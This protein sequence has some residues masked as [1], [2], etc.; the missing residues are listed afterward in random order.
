MFM[1]AFTWLMLIVSTSGV[2][3][4]AAVPWLSMSTGQAH[5]GEGV[6]DNKVATAGDNG[7]TT[8]SS[9]NTR[10]PQLGC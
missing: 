6:G 1:R 7:G 9:E 3:W 2:A 8:P 4:E 5:S 10:A